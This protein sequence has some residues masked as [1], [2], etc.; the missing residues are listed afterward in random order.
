MTG[1]SEGSSKNCEL[2]K[3][4]DQA[5]YSLRASCVVAEPYATMGA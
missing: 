4:A 5:A 1:A 2:S 3:D